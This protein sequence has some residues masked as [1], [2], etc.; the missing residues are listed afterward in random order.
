MAGRKWRRAAA[1]RGAAS[2]HY[3]PRVT[4]GAV[5]AD[6][7]IPAADRRRPARDLRVGRLPSGDVRLVGLPVDVVRFDGSA[8]RP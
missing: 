2:I 1:E 5:S 6:L 8:S 4:A 3:T 7:V